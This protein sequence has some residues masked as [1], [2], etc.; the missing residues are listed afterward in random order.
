MPKTYAQAR[1]CIDMLK[2][3]LGHLQGLVTF[4]DELPEILRLAQRFIFAA[5]GQVTAIKKVGKSVFIQ[6]A[7]NANMT[8]LN[9]KVDAMI[10]GTAAVKLPPSRALQD[11]ELLF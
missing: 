6:D 1:L 11:A 2:S 8:I 7:V 9:T 4:V 5:T 10:T 3:R